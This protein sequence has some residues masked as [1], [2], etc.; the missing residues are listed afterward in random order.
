M[1]AYCRTSGHAL[2]SVSEKDGTFSFL[3][4]KR[5]PAPAA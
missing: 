2:L 5:V 1:Q 4:E 3:I